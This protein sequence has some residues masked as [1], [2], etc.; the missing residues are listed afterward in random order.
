MPRVNWLRRIC[1]LVLLALWVP[2]TS[3]CAVETVLDWAADEHCVAAC[4]HDA[5]EAAEHVAN[6]ACA[7]LEGGAIKAQL[8]QL[9]APAP[10]YTT[11]LACLACV[12]AALLAEAEPPAPPAW[13][14][15]HPRDWMPVRHIAVR[16]V[17]PARAPNLI[18]G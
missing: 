5:S 18:R 11:V 1:A 7:T 3:H 17:A 6:D 15:G 10:S 2:A 4:A 14:G 13:S 9:V 12:H 16:A 8:G